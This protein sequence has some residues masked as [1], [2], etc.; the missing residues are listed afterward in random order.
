[1]WAW[2]ALIP[3]T[4]PG[5]LAWMHDATLHC[6]ARMDLGYTYNWLAGD[7]TSSGYEPACQQRYG[8]AMP[9]DLKLSFPLDYGTE[10]LLLSETFQ[11]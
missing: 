4:K 1:M 7:W 3:Q 8:A 10:D 9:R 2:T 5:S 6:T 11:A